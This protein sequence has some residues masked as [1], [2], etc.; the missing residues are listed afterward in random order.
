MCI[1]PG[2]DSTG[3]RLL[4]RN[5]KN[6]CMELAQFS[7]LSFS[8][9]FYYR[10]LLYPWKSTLAGLQ[11]GGGFGIQIDDIDK[12]TNEKLFFAY[13]NYFCATC[14]LPLQPIESESLTVS[15]QLYWNKRIHRLEPRQTLRI[16]I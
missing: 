8:D 10:P 5:G 11:R 16:L 4:L 15:Y 13:K 2:D 12:V 7:F 9:T 3:N 6:T 1:L 14:T